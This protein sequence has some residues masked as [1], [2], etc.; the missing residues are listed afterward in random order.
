MVADPI[1]T[2]HDMAREDIFEIL[3]TFFVST[4]PI[5]TRHDVAREDRLH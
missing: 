2:R 5:F 1:F 4:H 3:Q